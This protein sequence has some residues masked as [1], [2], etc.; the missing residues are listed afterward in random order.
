MRSSCV[1]GRGTETSAEV[2]VG[3]PSANASEGEPTAD[4]TLSF[5]NVSLAIERLQTTS[6]WT[7]CPGKKEVLP[8]EAAL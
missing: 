8:E 4:F 3:P 5:P 1:R 2:L 7:M 6:G